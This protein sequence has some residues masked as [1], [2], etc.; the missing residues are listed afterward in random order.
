MVRKV[1]PIRIE[2]LICRVALDF[3]TSVAKLTWVRFL[4][5][6]LKNLSESR[7][8]TSADMLLMTIA[9]PTVAV[10]LLV[11]TSE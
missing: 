7:Q 11:V 1:D 4:K 6:K 9:E 3:P 10:I 5:S 8:R 2:T